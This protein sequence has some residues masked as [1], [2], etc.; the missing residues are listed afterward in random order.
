MPRY[1]Y[2][3]R[4]A[5]SAEKHFGQQDKE[6]ELTQR[7]V[8]EATLIGAHL[9]KENI[10]FS[11][12]F[13]SSAVRAR[14]TAGI[15]ADAMKIDSDSIQIEDGLYDASTRTFFDFITQIENDL[16]HVLCVGH[17]PVISYLAES[18]TKEVIGDMPPGAIVTIK[19]SSDQWKTIQPGSGEMENYIRP[20]MLMA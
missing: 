5:E 3:L 9:Y 13:S 18:L 6:R 11:A 1:L 20:E 7:G 17:N 15:V 14:N 10:S 2:L 16:V 12:I 4:H 8:R 19:F